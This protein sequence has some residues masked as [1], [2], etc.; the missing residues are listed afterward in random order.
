MP[1][2]AQ[3]VG[4]KS[5]NRVN[6]RPAAEHQLPPQSP[7]PRVIVNSFRYFLENPFAQFRSRR[8]RVGYHKEFVDIVTFIDTAKQPFNK[9]FCFAGT[10]SRRYKQRAASVSHRRRLLNRKPYGGF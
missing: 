7:V 9:H 2:L 8:A 5:M 1:V 3:N 6:F 10:G 4:A